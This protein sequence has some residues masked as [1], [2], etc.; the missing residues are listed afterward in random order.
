M[1]NRRDFR[2]ISVDTA[3]ALTKIAVNDENKKKVSIKCSDAFEMN[4]DITL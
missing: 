2:M 1:P 3:N 4:K